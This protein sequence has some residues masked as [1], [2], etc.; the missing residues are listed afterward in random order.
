MGLP[1]LFKL[2]EYSKFEYHPRHFSP[3]KEAL[4]KRKSLI[5]SEVELEK[6]GKTI[7]FSTGFKRDGFFYRQAKVEKRSNVRL[8]VIMAVLVLF[9]Y[10][11]L[12]F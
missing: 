7:D 10:F 12:Y 8:I 4:E 6:N 5:R 11:L 2:P 1:T 9:A 3:Q